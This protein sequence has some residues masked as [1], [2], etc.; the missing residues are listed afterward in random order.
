MD[1]IKIARV[2][3]VVASPDMTVQDAALR[4][5]ESKVGAIVIVDSEEKILGIFTERDNLVRITCG[6]RDAKTTLLVDAMTTPVETALSDTTVEQGLTMMIRKRFRHL[7]IVD[8][9][10]H[11]LGIASLRYLLQRQIGQKQSS[12]E[13]LAAYVSAG[14]PG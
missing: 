11:I 13:T 6:N 3:A 9:D 14:G 2:P 5:A 7:P 1:L 4:M 12:I 10:R 8:V